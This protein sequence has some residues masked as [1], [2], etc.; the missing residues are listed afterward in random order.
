MHKRAWR[1]TVVLLLGSLVLA[2]TFLPVMGDGAYLGAPSWESLGAGQ[3]VSV[4]LFCPGGLE[5]G[6]HR[7][8]GAFLWSEPGG[9]P[10]AAPRELWLELGG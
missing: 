3:E 1:L 6:S 2:L 10:L 5:A 9:A 4:T 7:L 8:R